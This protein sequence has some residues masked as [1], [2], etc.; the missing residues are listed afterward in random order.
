MIDIKDLFQITKRRIF[1]L[2]LAAISGYIFLTPLKVLADQIMEKLNILGM[3]IL[4]G[5]GL[6]IS[7]IILFKKEKE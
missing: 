1:G 2:T 3:M 5:V 4:G 6:L 7:G